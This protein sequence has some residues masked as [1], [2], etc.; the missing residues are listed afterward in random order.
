MN[1]A[2][3]IA[4]FAVILL[5][6]GC[7]AFTDAATR[8]VYDL[9]SAA[10]KLKHDGDHFTLRHTPAERGDCDGPYTAQLDK[11]GA[12]VIW[13]RNDDGTGL[14]SAGSSCHRRVVHTPRTYYRQ[15]STVET[16]V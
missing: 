10:G 7:E 1:N 2:L 12:L 11:V 14:S 15:N 4:T 9:K 13:C 3:Q 8:L 5:L 6:S 16:L